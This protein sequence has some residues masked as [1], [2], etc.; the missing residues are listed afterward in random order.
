MEIKKIR[1]QGKLGKIKDSEI[2]AAVAASNAK[3]AA[4]QAK[5][6]N[7][8]SGRS[9]A[10]AESKADL[11]AF[12]DQLLEEQSAIENGVLFLQEGQLLV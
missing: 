11:Q 1:E 5:K 10:N 12:K 7:G 2:E 6:N 9:L 8:R 4:D 3:F